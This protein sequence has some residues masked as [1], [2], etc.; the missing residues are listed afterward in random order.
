MG[1]LLSCAASLGPLFPL[2]TR[3]ALPTPSPDEQNRLWTLPRA[4]LDQQSLCSSTA[5]R[6]PRRDCSLITC[7]SLVNFRASVY[8]FHR[9]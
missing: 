9:H 4:P 1:A 3:N 2:G 8:S 6:G 7:A 5:R